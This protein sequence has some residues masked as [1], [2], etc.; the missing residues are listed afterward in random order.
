MLY[1][2]GSKSEINVRNIWW[3]HILLD[4]Y[5]NQGGGGGKKEASPSRETSDSL[6]TNIYTIISLTY[7]QVT[8]APNYRL[9]SKF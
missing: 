4:F 1:D 5:V 6:Q 8:T 7:G 3:K 2:T 9:L